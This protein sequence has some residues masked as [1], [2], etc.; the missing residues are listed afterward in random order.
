MTSRPRRARLQVAVSDAQGRPLAPGLARWLT[1]VA[2]AAARGR[3]NIALVSDR[4]VRTLNQRYR[5]L[6]KPT[7]VLS[8][9]AVDQEPSTKDQGRTKDQEPRSRDHVLGDVIIATGVAR[10]QA[11]G[12]GH[13][14]E[15]ELRI[16]ALHGLLHLLGYDHETDDGAMARVER[17]LRRKGGLPE[18]L[19]ERA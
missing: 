3:V 4:Q 12:A 16:L 18:G 1:R 9:P 13:R 10:R 6:D 5:G 17:R 8:F 7:D 19:I 2:P 14:E 15:T 11:R